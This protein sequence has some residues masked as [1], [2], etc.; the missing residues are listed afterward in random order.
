MVSPFVTNGFVQALIDNDVDSHLVSR[1]DTLGNL[2]QGSLETLAHPEAGA[3]LATCRSRRRRRNAT[4]RPAYQALLADDGWNA[5][6]W[7]GSANAT[8]AAFGRNIEFLVQLKALKSRHGS[9]A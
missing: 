3:N 2:D 9:V 4:E 7:T 1:A 8:D 5:H 6:I